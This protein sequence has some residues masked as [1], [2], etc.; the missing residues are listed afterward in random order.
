[1]RCRAPVLALVFLTAG[2]A[3]AETVDHRDV[4]RVAALP[5]SVMD[6]IGQQKWFFA[7]ASLGQNCIGHKGLDVLYRGDPARYPLHRIQVEPAFGPAPDAPP[8]ATVAGGVYHWP[9]GQT[10]WRGKLDKLDK[11]VREKGWRWPAVDIVLDK[12]CFIDA[13][14]DAAAYLDRMAALERDCPETVFVYATMPLLRIDRADHPE[15]RDLNVLTNDYNRA[16][17]EG[18]AA[19]GK[20]LFDIADIEAHDPDGGEHTYLHEGRT[21]QAL[22]TGYAQGQSNYLNDLGSER[23]TLAWYAMAAAIVPEPS[24]AALLAAALLGMRGL[25]LLRRRSRARP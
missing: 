5:Q 20:L 4:D 2:P 21:Y 9:R 15:W 18:C 16:V 7:H 23:V 24:T 12:L 22:H 3:R 1:M 11:A 25:G 19:Q 10:D 8:A 6:A 13:G 17:R 14:A